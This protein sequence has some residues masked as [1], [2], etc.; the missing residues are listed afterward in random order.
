ML[1]W[2]AAHSLSNCILGDILPD[3]CMKADMVNFGKQHSTGN[4][5]NKA[6]S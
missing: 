1:P 4:E 6:K 5:N 3:A 2:M